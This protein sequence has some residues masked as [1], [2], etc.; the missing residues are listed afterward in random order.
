M[1]KEKGPVPK[2]RDYK[3][4]FG[5]WQKLGGEEGS[6]VETGSAIRFMLP[7]GNHVEV[8]VDIFA[9][10]FVEEEGLGFSDMP[11]VY[12]QEASGARDVV[13]E[14]LPVELALTVVSKERLVDRKEPSGFIEIKDY[15]IQI[16]DPGRGTFSA[17][18][19][20]RGGGWKGT[21]LEATWATR[22]SLGEEEDESLSE[23]LVLPNDPDLLGNLEIRVVKNS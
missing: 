3:I 23:T 8:K 16:K 15:S 22:W 20:D 13:F 19:F 2:E 12:E 1:R 11:P 21:Y 5:S 17:I 14:N 18:R 4:D 10:D 9:T 7:D 6:L